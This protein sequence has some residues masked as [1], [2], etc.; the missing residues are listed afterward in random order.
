[1]TWDPVRKVLDTGVLWVNT[2]QHLG[3]VFKQSR[4]AG[5]GAGGDVE[6]RLAAAEQHG[7]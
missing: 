6:M 1:M 4:M 2:G 7:W 5:V 3:F